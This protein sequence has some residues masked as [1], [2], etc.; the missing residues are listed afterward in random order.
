MGAAWYHTLLLHAH[1][2]QE[3]ALQPLPES[4][5]LIMNPDWRQTT[6]LYCGDGTL[7]HWPTAIFQWWTLTDAKLPGFS[8]EAALWPL[9]RPQLSNNL[10]WPTPNYWVLVWK[11]WMNTLDRRT[12]FVDWPSPDIFYWWP[13]VKCVWYVLVNVNEVIFF[14]GDYL[15]SCI[16][17]HR[18]H[19]N[20]HVRKRVNTQQVTQKQR[21]PVCRK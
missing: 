19:E 2:C 17:Y 1:K 9:D 6:R 13:A 3:T 12:F 15:V 5:F 21:T 20:Q 11:A 18:S 4:N 8:V 7:T 16:S 10:P 14:F